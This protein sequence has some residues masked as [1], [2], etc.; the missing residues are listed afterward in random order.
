MILHKAKQT[1][2]V[3]VI[4]MV[5][6]LLAVFNVEA[7]DRDHDTVIDALGQANGIALSCGYSTVVQEIKI[8]MVR[9]SPKL[10]EYRETFFNATNSFFIKQNSDDITC[11]SQ[12]DLRI[13]AQADIAALKKLSKPKK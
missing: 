8:A 3:V 11:P 6:L 2:S 13:A 4:L 7:K 5:T 9:Y 1:A 10:A 12:D